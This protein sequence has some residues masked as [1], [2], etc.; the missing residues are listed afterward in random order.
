MT[1]K[2]SQNHQFLATTMQFTTA[3]VLALAA[4]VLALPPTTNQDL[5]QSLADNNT[6]LWS[7]SPCGDF[8]RKAVCCRKSLIGMVDFSCHPA[9]PDIHTGL[10][11]AAACEAKKKLPRCCIMGI[12]SNPLTKP[13]SPPSCEPEAGSCE[14]QGVSR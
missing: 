10:E 14:I 8:A 4:G 6:D 7:A 5:E 2:H 1:V 9:K 3:T 13:S 12:V 11:L